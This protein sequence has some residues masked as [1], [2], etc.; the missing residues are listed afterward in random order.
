MKI[1]DLNKK[2][3]YDFCIKLVNILREYLNDEVSSFVVGALDLCQAWKAAGLSSNM[4]DYV[5][6]KDAVLVAMK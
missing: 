5:D 1:I 3:K 4:D 6:P 2:Q